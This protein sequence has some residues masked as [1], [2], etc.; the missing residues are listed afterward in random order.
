M[1]VKDPKKVAAGRAGA[2][3]RKAKQERLLEQL[4]AAKGSFRSGEASVPEKVADKGQGVA[5]QR[6][7]RGQTA[8]T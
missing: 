3:A 6:P 4:R 2:A 5:Q 7:R 1:E 8:G